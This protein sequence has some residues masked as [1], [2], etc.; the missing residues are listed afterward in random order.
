MEQ[1]GDVGYFV[2]DLC[3]INKGKEGKRVDKEESRR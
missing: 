2:D 1:F 3:P